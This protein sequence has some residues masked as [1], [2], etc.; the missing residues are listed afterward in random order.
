MENGMSA[1]YALIVTAICNAVKGFYANPNTLPS[2]H[3]V[4]RVK[5]LRIVLSDV[6]RLL[7]NSEDGKVVNELAGVKSAK[8]IVDDW[9]KI[10]EVLQPLVVE[11]ESM[12]KVWAVD[13]CDRIVPSAKRKVEYESVERCSDCHV[14]INKATAVELCGISGKICGRCAEAYRSGDRPR[15]PLSCESCME[16]DCLQRHREYV[17]Q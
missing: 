9:G 14:Q 11:N 2:S 13:L 1:L 17:E 4:Q 10:P 7:G 6:V 5:A 8:E 16:R 15:P 3:L 12:L